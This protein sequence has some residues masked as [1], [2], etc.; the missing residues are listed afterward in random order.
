MSFYKTY[1]KL[2]TLKVLHVI[3]FNEKLFITFSTYKVVISCFKIMNE[4]AALFPYSGFWCYYAVPS[5][6][7][8]LQSCGLFCLL[9]YAACP[10]D[11]PTLIGASAAVLHA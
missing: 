5:M 9:C 11:R 10:F 7:M 6:R 1:K 2:F 3:D 8:Y 4:E